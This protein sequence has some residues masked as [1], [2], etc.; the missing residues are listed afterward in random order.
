MAKIVCVLYPDPVT[1]YPPTYARDE[2]RPSP[3]TPT[4]KPRLHRRDLWG[5]NRANSS[6]RSQANWV[7]ATIWRS[8]A[9]SSS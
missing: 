6:G 5:F 8:S 3:A 4:A 7:F 1:G 2:S 9:M